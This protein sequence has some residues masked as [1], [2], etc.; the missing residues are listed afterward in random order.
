MAYVKG[1]PGTIIA[2]SNNQ[3]LK[4]DVAVLTEED[5]Q[6][7]KDANEQLAGAALRVLGVAYREL[8]EGFDQAHLFSDLTLVGLVGMSDPLREEAKEAIETCRGAGIRTVMITGDQQT[9]AAEIA[10]QWGIDV[11]IDGRRLRTVH[12]SELEGLDEESWK[13][14]VADVAVFARVSPEHQLQIV[15]ALQRQGHIVA[16]T[17]DRVNDAPALKKAD[18]GIAMGIKGTEVAK[19]NADMVITDDNFA[20]IVGAVEQGRIITSVTLVAFGI[21]M[22]WHGNEGEGLVRATTMA[23]MTMAL[24][25]VFHVFNSR[26]QTRSAFTSRFFTNKWLWGAIGICLALQC[27]AVYVPLLQRVLHTVPPTTV[28]WG[29]IAGCSLFPLVVVELVKFA[30]LAS[31]HSGSGTKHRSR[32]PKVVV[33]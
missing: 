17:G 32:S 4:S 18:I 1:A 15:D 19:E 33:P 29:V 8:P 14:A 23:F 21:G 22:R 13:N 5:R 9:T 10:T 28:E 25:Q 11:D 7:W 3:L 16:M 26:S 2:A 12:G 30:R 6:R 27:A 20:S 31:K 24:S